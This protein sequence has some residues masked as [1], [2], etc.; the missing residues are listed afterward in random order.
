MLV[1]RIA[2]YSVLISVC[3]TLANVGVIASIYF[4]RSSTVKRALCP[5][6]ASQCCCPAVCK[7]F[8]QQIADKECHRSTSSGLNARTRKDSSSSSCF[9]KAGCGEQDFLVSS[10]LFQKILVAR[11]RITS[12]VVFQV[13]FL[14]K[15]LDFGILPGYSSRFF[16][17]PRNSQS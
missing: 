4:S 8:Q 6:H 13:S 16:H 12:K 7:D 15:G 17:P 10:D 14:S 5:L 11:S 9:L 3:L 2:A 1:K